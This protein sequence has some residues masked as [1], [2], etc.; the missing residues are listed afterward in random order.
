MYSKYYSHTARKTTETITPTV[1]QTKPM[2]SYTST[3]KTKTEDYYPNFVFCKQKDLDWCKGN[4]HL[5]LIYDKGFFFVIKVLIFEYIQI[6][7]E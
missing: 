2:R 4:L 5:N 7:Q 3:P 1:T 6:K